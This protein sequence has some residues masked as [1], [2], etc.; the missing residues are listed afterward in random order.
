MIKPVTSVIVPCYNQGD[1][2]A[3][4]L[5]SIFAQTYSNWE[6]VIVD[7]GSTDNS[8]EVALVFCDKDE[9]FHYHYQANQG[10]SAARNNG[11]KI[12]HGKYILPLDADDLIHR[13]YLAEAVEVLEQREDV[14]VVYCRAEYFGEKTGEW[15][16]P[17]FNMMEILYQNCIF[18]TSMY[19]RADFDQTSGYNTNMKY[20][21]EDWDFWLSLLESGGDVYQIPYIRFFYRIKKK[22]MLADLNRSNERNRKM[23]LTVMEN[24]LSL[25]RKYYT[26]LYNKY[27]DMTNS[28]WYVFFKMFRKLKKSLY[29]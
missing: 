5:E 14:K 11:I 24:H 21:L 22:S 2:L 15:K 27:S 1:F 29:R 7:D 4:T 16:L 20:G 10:L 26:A 13:D 25:Y 18:C 28:K 12:C 6:C 23:A 19:R 3:E 9:R 17:K 8:K